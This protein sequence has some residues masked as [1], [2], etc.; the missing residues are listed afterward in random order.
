M[1]VRIPRGAGNALAVLLMAASCFS[2]CARAADE[3]VPPIYVT[4]EGEQMSYRD[5]IELTALA[6][7]SVGIFKDAV[8]K[9]PQEMPK[10]T[11]YV[12]YA[13]KDASGKPIIWMSSAISG[14]QKLSAG[15]NTE[16]LR[17][18]EAA[19]LLAMLDMGRGTSK[20]HVVFE[21]LKSDPARIAALGP[22]LTS[23]MTEMSRKTVE[24]SNAQRRWIFSSIPA[25][26]PRARVYEMLRAHSLTAS[27][28]KGVIVVS[29]PGA[30]EPGCYFSTNVLLTFDKNDRLYK[31]DLGQP[32]PDCL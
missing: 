10:T 9:A 23:A 30:F 16:M 22:E 6:M 24:Y 11:P 13:G 26:K 2:V 19:A 5:V 7:G 12:Y 28:T 14:K 32:I 21:K 20:W 4:V 29:L 17:E 8:T 3:N 18:Q 1:R 15:Q 31:A 25:G 27:E